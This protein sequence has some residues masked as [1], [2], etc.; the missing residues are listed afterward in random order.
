M[1]EI[2]PTQNR[3]VVRRVAE[4]RPPNQ[5]VDQGQISDVAKHPIERSGHPVELQRLHQQS[6]V[7][8]LPAGASS[9]E[10]P[11]LLI[12]SPTSPCRLRLKR[13]KSAELSFGLE[14]LLYGVGSDR[15]DELGFEICITN[16]E[17]KLLHTE[18]G[19]VRTES[20][21]LEV[22]PSF[23]LFAGV[24]QAGQFHIEPA[25]S[26]HTEEVTESCCAAN[27]NHG[28]P[29]RF[30]IPAGTPGQCFNS[31]LVAAA[32][33]QYHRARSRTGGSR[34]GQPGDL[35]RDITNRE[36]GRPRHRRP[37]AHRLNRTSTINPL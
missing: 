37:V 10:A 4:A 33:H 9:H 28:H 29:L 26:Q 24:A 18:A 16:E 19:Q 21:S 2:H 12:D 15:T 34:F 31:H 1:K 35:R 27:R 17:A 20:G 14:D 11:E 5:L 3:R 8:D 22:A 6:A 23:D 30:E 32:F 36:L 25:R 7:S 13:A